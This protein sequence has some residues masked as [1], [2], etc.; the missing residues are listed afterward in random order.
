MSGAL[1]QGV[2]FVI[3]EQCPRKVLAAADRAY[4]LAR[5]AVQGTGPAKEVEGD[6]MGSA[7]LGEQS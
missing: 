3:V 7:Y 2:A 4:L 1:E 6:A 5:V